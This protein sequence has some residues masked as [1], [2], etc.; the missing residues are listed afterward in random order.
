[1]RTVSPLA[2]G[3]MFGNTPTGLLGSM[4]LR[5]QGAQ[6]M[7]DTI[8][9]EPGTPLAATSA[10]QRDQLRAGA[11][12]SFEMVKRLWLQLRQNQTTPRRAVGIS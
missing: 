5:Y 1:M 9:M 8:L 11:R 2:T 10:I 7:D 6:L 12:Q 3:E 4:I